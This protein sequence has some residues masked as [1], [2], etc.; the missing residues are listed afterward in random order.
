[1]VAATSSVLDEVTPNQMTEWRSLVRKD[2]SNF[3]SM[4]EQLGLVPAVEGLSEWSCWLT[5]LN[6][7][8]KTGRRFDTLFYTHFI[9]DEVS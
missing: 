6:M 7:A 3:V 9:K 1:M 4:C 5:P 8:A 2:P